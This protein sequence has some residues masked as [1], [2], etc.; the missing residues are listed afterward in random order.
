MTATV[1]S[2]VLLSPGGAPDPLLTDVAAQAQALAGAD[3]AEALAWAADL[4]D[5][6]PD[7]GSGA[8]RLRWEVLATVAAQDLTVARTIEP[9]LDAVSILHE[10]GGSAPAGSTWGVYAAEGPPPR[11]EAV[12]DGP[13]WWVLT[14]RKPWCSLASVVS[15]A[16][17]TAWV[18]PTRR[19]LFEVD[20]SHPGV[21]GDDGVWAARGLTAITSTALVM[22]AVP[23]HAVGGPGWY[24]SRPGFAW[25]GIGVAAVWYGGA[26]GVARRL[27]RAVRDREPDQVGLMH[28]G[29]VDA[30]LTSARAVLAEAAGLVDGVDG[31]E[32]GSLTG[33]GAALLAARVRH[34]VSSAAETV[35]TEVGHA[36]GPAPLSQEPDHA[37]RVADLTL[38]LRQHHAARD[39]AAS[40]RLLA[41]GDSP[42]W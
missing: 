17:V 14:G 10:A 33:D 29:V 30:A 31:V 22:G 32:G 21:S 16:L 1:A 18:E 26:V 25:G 12:A 39:S 27:A 36:L 28:L 8:T 11:L 40:G 20:L 2:P 15:H 19:G 6:V 13:G 9:H 41:D 34:V 7:P 24:L 5:L 35:L 23:A 3:V 37:A 4:A 42:P 38:Y